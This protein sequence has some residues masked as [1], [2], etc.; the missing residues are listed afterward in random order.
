MKR[1]LAATLASLVVARQ[2]C[3]ESGNTE[4]KERHE[5]RILA[6]VNNNLPSGSGVDNGTKI[7]LDQSTGEKLVFQADFHH[8]DEGGVYDGWTEHTVTVKASL[9]YGL[10]I[11]IGGRDRD[12]IKDHIYVLFSHSLNKTVNEGAVLA[13]D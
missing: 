9:A 13:T 5:D 11:K 1:S 10:N 2:N 6:L 3:I 8:M 4:W 7:D 12:S